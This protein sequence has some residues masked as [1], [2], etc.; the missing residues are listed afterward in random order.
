[1]AQK[2]RKTAAKGAPESAKRGVAAWER[3]EDACSTRHA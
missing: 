3:T 1:M 2:P